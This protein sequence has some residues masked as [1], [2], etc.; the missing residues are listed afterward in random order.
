MTFSEM[1]EFL[2]SL[3]VANAVNLDGGGSSTFV[4][5]GRVMN[6]PSDATGERPVAN[7]IHIL[8]CSIH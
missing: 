4:L 1:A 8:N 7:T 6:C 3:G 5:F 2:R